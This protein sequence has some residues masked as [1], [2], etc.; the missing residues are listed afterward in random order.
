M[1]NDNDYKLK[2]VDVVTNAWRGVDQAQP[3]LVDWGWWSDVQL[4]EY[5]IS[6]QAAKLDAYDL[7]SLHFEL[8]R[9]G[10]ETESGQD[11]DSE[12]S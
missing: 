3:D 2:M 4:A 12:R 1:S 9:R 10:F 6:P 7:E 8:E 11:E 5:A